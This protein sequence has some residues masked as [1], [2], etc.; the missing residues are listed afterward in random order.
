[1]ILQELQSQHEVRRAH[2]H[3]ERRPHDLQP[4]FPS[5]LDSHLA[6]W[7]PAGRSGA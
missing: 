6:V 7:P 3:Q 5:E 4:F 2:G 1:M